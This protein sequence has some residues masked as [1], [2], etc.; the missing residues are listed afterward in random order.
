[1]TIF[2]PS[3]T[4]VAPCDFGG[5]SASGNIS[6]Y[7]D[8]VA[9]GSANPFPVKDSGV[10]ALIADGA[11]NVGGK[12]SISGTP[13]VSLSGVPSVSL[14]GALPAGGN[15]LGSVSISNFP[16]TQT[17]GG[18]VSISGTASVSLAGASSISLSGALPAGTNMLGT[19][20]LAA[21][22]A[23]SVTTAGTGGT[24]AQA[25]QGIS[26]GVPLTMAGQVSQSGTWNV[27]VSSLPALSAG[28]N[29][30]GSVSVSNLPATQPVSGSVAV[31]S[32]PTLPA[33]TS[34]IGTV[35]LAAGSVGSVTAAGTG[36]TVAQAVQGIA[37][38]VALPVSGTFWPATQPVS[39]ASLPLPAG[40]ALDSDLIAP[41]APV[42]P[43]AATATKSLVIGCLS[44]T[45][46]PSFTAGQEG[47]VP[48]DASGRPY[49]VT[50]PSANNVPVF[51]QALTGGGAT[52]ASAV[53]AAASCMATNVK[54]TGSGMVFAY[55]VSNSN[56]TP[57]WFRLFPLATAPICGSS[58]PTKRIFV[59]GGATIGLSTDMGWVF[60]LGIGFDV[61][62]GS[63]ADSDTTT[64]AAAN[65]VLVNIDYK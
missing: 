46:L 21:G 23:G 56:S 9:V 31:S 1:V 52:T 19:I 33:G 16:A 64:V 12:V 2:C 38:G 11:L 55:S 20:G 60:S 65:S 57:V 25:V 44:N 41:Y 30:I 26:G 39:V 36:G 15:A 53:N 58:T 14:T 62:A 42:A 6:V 40:A 54:S 27:G 35:G 50:V 37:G 32:L 45:T 61:T 51:L 4:G 17:V 29:A 5:G 24:V 13:T 59:P 49:V 8:G 3:G 63:G 47:A 43:A 18:S 34:N 22:A 48:C 10:D 28:S 7:L